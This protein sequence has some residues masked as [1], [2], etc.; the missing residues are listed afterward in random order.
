MNLPSY[1][2]KY[3]ESPYAPHNA[4]S[5]NQTSIFWVMIQ[6]SQIQHRNSVPKSAQ[7]F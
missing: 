6:L 7:R 4:E 1:C 2:T 5:V 3:T